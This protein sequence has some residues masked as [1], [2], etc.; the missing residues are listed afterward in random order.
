MAYGDNLYRDRVREYLKSHAV[1]SEIQ[2]EL[3]PIGEYRQKLLNCRVAIFGHIRQQAVGNIMICM[4]SG[5]KVF[6]FKDS[7]AFKFFKSIGS[8][9]F[10]IEDELTKEEIRKPLTE[11][12]KEVNIRN[13]GRFSIEG[14]IDRLGPIIGLMKK[15]TNS[16]I[17]CGIE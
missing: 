3:M 2:N 5:M 17:D 13:L 14:I 7:V 6:L 16:R 1:E 8:F 9:V 4:R 10:S 15:D 11:K 12:E